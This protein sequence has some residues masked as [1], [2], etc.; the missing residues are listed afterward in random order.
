MA[1]SLRRAL[2][3]PGCG[4]RFVSA[5]QH[6]LAF[7]AEVHIAFVINTGGQTLVAALDDFW[8]VF[9]NQVVVLHRL[10]RQMKACHVAHLARPQAACVYDHFGVDGAFRSH[11][12][13]AAVGP[14]VGLQ[15]RGMGVKLGAMH[16]GCFGVGIGHATGVHVAIQRVPQR[17]DVA[18]GVDQRMAACGLLDADELLVQPHIAGLGALTLE[19]IV[20]GRV[21]GQ[22]EATCVV[23]ANRVARDFF[24]LFVE[25]DG[26]TLQ[27]RNVRV[28]RN[29]VN[30]ACS[31]PA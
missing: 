7:L 26:V 22:I 18:L 1:E 11:H 13:P 23:H 19:V 20:P 17:C 21:G 3:G 9:G 14:L 16:F 29:G 24:N 28:A 8:N 30:L 4:S 6:A 2:D 10:H 31:V 25:L 12:V 15:H 27:P 5:Q